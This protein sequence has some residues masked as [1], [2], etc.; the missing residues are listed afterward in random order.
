MKQRV[1]QRPLL[2]ERESQ[3]NAKR[4]AEK[5]YTQILRDAGVNEHLVNKLVTKDG[6]IVDAEDSEDDAENVEGRE[7]VD[8]D[9]YEY[10]LSDHSPRTESRSEDS[11]PEEISDEDD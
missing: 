5:K 9:N 2:F 4:K 8:D 3:E 10:P 11:E 1:E 7:E 6:G